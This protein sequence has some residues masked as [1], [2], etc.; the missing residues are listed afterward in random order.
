MF[1]YVF[2]SSLRSLFQVRRILP[3]ILLGV[4]TLAAAVLWRRY[5]PD[6][7]LDDIYARISGVIVFKVLALVSAIYTTAIIGQEVE[8]RTIVYLLTRPIPRWILLIARYLATVVATVVVTFMAGVGASVG[9][10]GAGALGNPILWRDTAAFALGAF[11]YCALFLMISLLFNRAMIICIIY[12]FVVET[13]LPNFPG[14]V[15]Y[16]SIATFL[17]PISDHPATERGGDLLRVLAGGVNEGVSA[18]QGWLVLGLASA[19]LVGL[20]A[21]WFTRFEYVPRED[22][23]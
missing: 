10:F 20:A 12:A 14:D 11:A 6:A 4:G 7:R 17:K 8:Q 9:V 15:R 2:L 1:G 5:V 13:A 18:T 16:L 19:I 3:W 23:E 21:L 22:A